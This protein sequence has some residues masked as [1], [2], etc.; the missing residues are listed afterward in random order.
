MNGAQQFVEA[1]GRITGLIFFSPCGARRLTRPMRR[2]A[3]PSLRSSRVTPGASTSPSAAAHGRLAADRAGAT[4]S[5][6]RGGGSGRRPGR[7]PA[8]DAWAI[9]S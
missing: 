7:P 2:C 8:S 3:R 9:T 4:Q 6:H 5:A 1:D